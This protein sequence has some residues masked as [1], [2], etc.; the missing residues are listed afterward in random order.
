[1]VKFSELIFHLAMN[2]SIPIALCVEEHRYTKEYEEMEKISMELHDF[3]KKKKEDKKEDEKKEEKDYDSYR[4]I[5]RLSCQVEKLIDYSKILNQKVYLSS[6]SDKYGNSFLQAR[7]SLKDAFGKTKWISAYLGSI[8]NFD[9][10]DK[11]P[12][13]L[14]KGK[15]L[16]REKLRAFYKL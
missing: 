9:K 12:I 13:A 8:Q 16:I 7:T 5:Y 2:G 3:L 15:E 11:D 4:A 1:M 14:K 6:Y 10:G